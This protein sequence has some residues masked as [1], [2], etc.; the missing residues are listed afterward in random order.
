MRKGKSSVLNGP[1]GNQS[2]IKKILSV[3]MAVH[4]FLHNR[5][6]FKRIKEGFYV[7]IN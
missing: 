7:I 4:Y 5:V 3:Q 2:V 6:F 1:R